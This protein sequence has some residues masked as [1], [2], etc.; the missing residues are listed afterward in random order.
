MYKHFL[1]IIL[2]GFLTG[3][4]E[5]EKKNSVPIVRYQTYFYPGKLPAPAQPQV[6]DTFTYWKQFFRYWDFPDSINREELTDRVELIHNAM[7]H[8]SKK[9]FP[10]PVD[11]VDIKS[12]FLRL[13]NETYQLK[14]ILA[15]NLIY[16]RPDS[17]FS[18][19]TEAYTNLIHQINFFTGE[20][21]DFITVFKE[22]TRR[23]SLLLEKFK[24]DS[25][26]RSGQ[27]AE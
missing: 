8:I 19:F 20:K 6:F 4:R 23:D 21:E 11:T 13:Q 16:P 26:E 2:F 17:I 7:A 14:W 5:T 9:P 25:T 27:M 15:E 24:R 1:I 12:R 10:K 3:C 22:K 18:R